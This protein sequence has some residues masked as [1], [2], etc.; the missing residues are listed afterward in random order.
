M[1]NNP[2]NQK[3]QCHTEG[4][5]PPAKKARLTATDK[6]IAMESPKQATSQGAVKPMTKGRAKVRRASPAGLP[7]SKRARWTVTSVLIGDFLDQV[8]LALR[9]VSVDQPTSFLAQRPNVWGQPRSRFDSNVCQYFVNQ[10]VMDNIVVAVRKFAMWSVD[11]LG[12]LRGMVSLVSMFPRST[13][14]AWG[15]WGLKLLHHVAAWQPLSTAMVEAALKVNGTTR[16][17]IHT[18]TDGFVALEI[19]CV[20][21]S[22]ALCICPQVG[23]PVNRWKWTT[24]AV[25]STRGSGWPAPLPRQNCMPPCEGPMPFPLLPMGSSQEVN[26]K[27]CAATTAPPSK[28]RRLARGEDNNPMD[29]V[30]TIMATTGPSSTWLKPLALLSAALS[31]YPSWSSV[32]IVMTSKPSNRPDTIASYIPSVVDRYPGQCG[33][34][35]HSV[36]AR[37]PSCLKS[38]GALLMTPLL[39]PM[40]VLVLRAWPSPQIRPLTDHTCAPA[41]VHRTWSWCIGSTQVIQP[42]RPAGLLTWKAKDEAVHPPISPIEPGPRMS[43]QRPRTGTKRPAQ[44]VLSPSKRAR[45]G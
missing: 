34:I 42:W 32:D 45:L 24:G 13:W 5:P 43:A 14:D 20:A 8:A 15:S 3:A 41:L 1:C 9:P 33:I 21:M 40:V 11:W 28:R 30:E 19:D 6:V 16:Y 27:R 35:P 44:E 18:A 2:V 31:S 37:H 29:N 4:L 10:T 25:S 12:A 7:P 22:I 23:G 39:R 38:L 26:R 17:F 36:V